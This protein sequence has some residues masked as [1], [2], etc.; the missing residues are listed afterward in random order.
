M[1]I[2]DGIDTIEIPVEVLGHHNNIFPTLLWDTST[3]MLVDAG[4]QGQHSKIIDSLSQYGVEKTQLGHLVFTHQDIDHIGGAL[5]IIQSLQG[6]VITYTS[7]KEKP[8][9]EGKKRLI[10]MTEE[11]INRV[12]AS[13]PADWP[14]EMKASFRLALENCPNIRIDRVIEDGEELSLFGGLRVLGTPGHTPGHIS[15]YHKKTK[16]LI[17]G[18]CL[19]S[20]DGVLMLPREELC[21]DYARATASLSRLLEYEIQTVICYHGGIVREK[22][23]HKIERVLKTA[24]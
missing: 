10:K 19:L 4:Y 14:L 6:K 12:M 7:E 17:A 24:R 9:I 20:S 22:I 8:Y 13:T 5:N 1:L 18:D 3:A 15:I 11:T 21:S 23:N 2:A 16:T